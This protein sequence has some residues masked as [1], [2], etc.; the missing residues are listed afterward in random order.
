[1]SRENVEVV[2]RWIDAYNARDMEGILRA[3][4]PDFEFRSIFVAVESVFRAPEG[5]PYE[6][7]KT[8]DEAYRRFVITP[9]EQLIDAG[10]AVVMVATA[11]WVGR[12]SGAEGRTPITTAFWL[13]DRKVFRAETYTER[14]RARAAVGLAQ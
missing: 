9:T 10:A 7:F 13:K 5:F 12:A 2:R 1:M 8:L 4:E 14:V 6:Y 11:D 3:I